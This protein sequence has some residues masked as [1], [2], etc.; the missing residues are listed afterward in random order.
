MS[1]FYHRIYPE[2]LH[3]F[4]DET[5]KKEGKFKYTKQATFEYHKEHCTNSKYFDSLMCNKNENS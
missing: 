1:R 3:K 4:S 2:N 5:K